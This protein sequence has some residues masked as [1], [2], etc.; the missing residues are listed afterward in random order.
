LSGGRATFSGLGDRNDTWSYDPAKKEWT[1][2]NPVFNP[3]PRSRHTSAYDAANDLVVVHGGRTPSDTW[4]FDAK[5]N[6]WFEVAPKEQPPEGVTHLEYD[7]GNKCFIARNP[8]R[9]SG[10]IWVLR[11]QPTGAAPVPTPAPTG[12]P[13]FRAEWRELKP[14]GEKPPPR[15]TI[16]GNLSYDPKRKLCVLFGGEGRN[17]TWTLDLAALR[18]T[19]L[20]QDDPKGPAAGVSRPGKLYLPQLLCEEAADAWWVIDPESFWVFSPEA[21]T[22]KKRE[23]PPGMPNWRSA[24]VRNGWAYD[25]DGRRFMRIYMGGQCGFFYPA[26]NRAEQLPRAWEPASAYLD[27][28][29]TYDR[30][31]K[32]FVLFGGGAKG[33]TLLFDPARKLWRPAQPAAGPPARARHKLVWH[34][35]LGAVVLAGGQGEGGRWLDDLWVFEAAAERWTEVRLAAGPPAAEQAVA[36]AAA[37]DVV[38]CFN[39]KGQTWALRIERAGK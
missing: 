16:S 23:L 20:E 4:A 22:W 14:A 34:D 30:S 2:L 27:G 31:N 15:Q 25:P 37:Q 26:E 6:G 3:P 38:A 35:K 18:W 11:I 13:A 19:C 17:D 10:E 29:L 24:N 33:G 39:D 21:R 36:Y 9:G 28:G 5:R 8:A 7:P 12:P 1:E 32:V